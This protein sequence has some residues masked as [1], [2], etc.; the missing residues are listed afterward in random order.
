MEEKSWN[1]ESGRNI[2]AQETDRMLG[3]IRVGF[4][5]KEEIKRLTDKTFKETSYTLI[6]D[7]FIFC[8]FTGLSRA[9]WQTLPKRACKPRSTGIC[10]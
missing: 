4:L 5:T 2:A 6:R 3:K 7:L 9:I 8:T 10:G 1:V